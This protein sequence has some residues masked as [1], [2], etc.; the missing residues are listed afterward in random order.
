MRLAG[1][2]RVAF[3]VWS[4]SSLS[5]VVYLAEY[6]SPRSNLGE[7]DGDSRHA[8]R[9]LPLEGSIMGPAIM[10]VHTVLSSKTYTIE[11]RR[12]PALREG[13]TCV[14]TLFAHVDTWPAT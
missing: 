3:H 1:F 14:L 12:V 11:Q 2:S 4:N 5:S 10:G 13:A 7:G 6:I 8:R 9:A